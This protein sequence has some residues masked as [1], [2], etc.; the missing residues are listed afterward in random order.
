MKYLYG[1][2]WEKYSIEENEIWIDKN[3]G[4]KLIVQD[5]LKGLPDIINNVDMLYFDPPWSQGNITC[6]LTKAEKQY[7][8]DY[9]KFIDTI[10]IYI[11]SI[12][13]KVVYMEIG[14]QNLNMVLDKFND[15]FEYVQHW[16]I[17]YYKKNPCYLIRGSNYSIVD[18][19]FTD[20]D[21]TITPFIAIENEKDLNIKT[22]GDFCTGQGL[23]ALAS[24]EYNKRF[25]GVE[26]N[27]RRM[28]V[29]IDRCNKKG[30]NYVRL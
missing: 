8:I 23:T 25:V 19:D 18:V 16:K 1:K 26:L 28:A 11:E 10:F 9:N 20:L 6:F 14:K 24:L 5:I 3:T 4:S 17:L 12:Q 21:D 15:M 22:I 7:K 13:P 2:S 30:A 29:T 27:K